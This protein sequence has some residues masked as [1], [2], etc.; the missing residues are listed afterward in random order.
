[1]GIAGLLE[2]QQPDN[3]SSDARLVSRQSTL[4]VCSRD[5]WIWGESSIVVL[6]H[7]ECGAIKALYDLRTGRVEFLS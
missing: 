6:G 1:M 4:G 5:A 2:E 7:S 3:I